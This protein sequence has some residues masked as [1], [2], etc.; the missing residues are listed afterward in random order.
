MT[1]TSESYRT[2]G[3][4]AIVWRH[5]RRTPGPPFKE[6]TITHSRMTLAVFHDG[7]EVVLFYH[8]WLPGGRALADTLAT[9]LGL[10]Y[11]KEDTGV[12]GPL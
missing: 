9:R 3:L 11:R 12:Q 10:A 6:N 4:T 5:M 1:S 7:R 8:T 2:A